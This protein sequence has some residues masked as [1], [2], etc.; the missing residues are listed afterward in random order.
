[1]K[2]ETYMDKLVL[3]TQ[4]HIYAQ[5]RVVVYSHTVL[6]YFNILNSLSGLHY[7]LSRSHHPHL[8]L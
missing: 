2:S 8:L 1:M 4:F 7:S 6:V 5:I 3:F